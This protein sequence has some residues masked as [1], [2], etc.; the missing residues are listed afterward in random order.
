MKTFNSA[1]TE[2]GSGGGGSPTVVTD[3]FVLEKELFAGTL[4]GT[5]SALDFDPVDG[6]YDDLVIR[7]WGRSDRSNIS[8]NMTMRFNADAGSTNYK[9]LYQALDDA[10]PFQGAFD[11]FD[12]GSVLTAANSTADS[13]GFT[14]IVI[15]QY[16]GSDRKLAYSVGM[17]R[18]ADA[19]QMSLYLT[20]LSWENT[21][22]I[23]RVVLLSGTG[24]NFV[25]GMRYQVLGRKVT[26]VVTSVT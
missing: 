13:Y 17:R 20:H 12:L 18:Q 22:P 8:D 7:V 10:T 16:A 15:P 6:S 23:T 3:D 2:R 26:T 24:S 9:C 11:G 1:G 5:T 4:S 21:S 25:S 19:N 14:E